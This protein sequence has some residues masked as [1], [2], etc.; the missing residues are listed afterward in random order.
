MERLALGLA[1]ALAIG[2]ALG[3]T[4]DPGLPAFL[5]ASLVF[6]LALA[7]RSSLIIVLSVLLVGI[8][9]SPRSSSFLQEQIPLLREVVGRVEGGPEPHRASV[10]FVL[11]AAGLGVDLL[12]YLRTDDPLAVDLRS[13]ST[14]RLTGEGELP[15][16]SWAE[17]LERRGI[18]GVFWGETCEVLEE[19]P[20]SFLSWI[21]L[22]RLRLLRKLF[23]TLPPSGAE[24]LA[25]LLLGTRGLLPEEHVEAF[26]AAGAAHLLALS[27][28]HLGILA[29]IG[30][31][32]LGLVKLR[33]GWRYLVLL[34]CVW[35]YV[36]LGGGR[37]SLVRAAIM[38]SLLGGFYLLWELGLVLKSWHDPLESLGLA[39]LAAL[40]LWPWSPLDLGFQ[41]SFCAT[42]SILVLWSAWSGNALRRRLPRPGKWIADTLTT[43]AF[44]QVGTLPIVGSAFG[45]LAPWGFLA[46]LILIP[47]TGLLL[48]AG[49][50]LLALPQVA[51][52]ALGPILQK[53]LIGPYLVTVQGLST[54][55]GAM[56]PVG[57]GFGPW[58]LLCAL[59]AL[60]LRVV[61]EEFREGVPLPSTGSVR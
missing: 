14:V 11:E 3:S 37:V 5:A 29:A 2:L 41:L 40:L 18:A 57:K 22:A 1:A 61:Q 15:Q 32:L 30:W 23:S 20:G 33:P 48:G 59:G 46:N 17:Y 42:F 36:F 50:L 24:L 16:G 54:L 31:W 10:S 38:F 13:G 55:P 60:L 8:A 53:V 58:C 56:L 12:V 43:T 44:A 19:G 6:L 35:G 21:C 27:G 51:A 49:L 47:W 4:W 39:A 45:H 9:L 25:A 26:R 52:Q 7:T 28:L 34:P